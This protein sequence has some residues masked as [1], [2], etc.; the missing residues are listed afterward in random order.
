MFAFVDMAQHVGLITYIIAFESDASFICLFVPPHREKNLLISSDNYGRDLPSVQ[1]LQKKQQHFETEVDGR[2]YKVQQLLSGRAEMELTVVSA[3]R[4]IKERCGQLQKLW[5]D[6]REVSEKRYLR[7]TYLYAMYNM[8][9]DQS[10]AKTFMCDISSCSI[11]KYCT[12]Y[13]A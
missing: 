12:S 3:E 9:C 6:L 4:E 8:Q 1:N 2:E 10:Q 13:I 7:M 5:T 11:Y